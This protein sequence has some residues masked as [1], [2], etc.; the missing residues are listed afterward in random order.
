MH[1]ISQTRK[2]T[3]DINMTQERYGYD[4]LIKSFLDRDISVEEFEESYFEKIRED[5]NPM[6]DELFHILDWLFA[7]IDYF[8]NDPETFPDDYITEDQLRDSA[9]QTLQKLKELE[10]RG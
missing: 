5:K 7:E 2:T 9:A 8:S 4:E 1:A 6:S 3:P 10:A